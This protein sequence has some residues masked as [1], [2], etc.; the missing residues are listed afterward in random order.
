VR[1][2]RAR[3]RLRE[4][5][6]RVAPTR[7]R[8]PRL[9]HSSSNDPSPTYRAMRPDQPHARVEDCLVVLGPVEVTFVDR[10]AEAADFGPLAKS[11]LGIDVVGARGRWP[12]P[13]RARRARTPSRRRSRV[14]DRWPRPPL[15]RRRPA[16][17]AAR[18]PFSLASRRARCAWR[19]PGRGVGRRSRQGASLT[20]RD[21]TSEPVP[22]S[23]V[24]IT[25]D[26][27]IGHGQVHDGVT[28]EFEALIGRP[29]RA[30][31]RNSNESA[32][33]LAEDSSGESH[34]LPLT[35]QVARAARLTN[36]VRTPAI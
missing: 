5:R 19:S 28:E 31:R 9:R 11:G 12:R 25:R 4:L 29:R 30:R 14:L 36:L 34:A 33:T 16:V 8:R 23:S 24:G 18:S 1:A 26:D 2:T 17:R 32:P 21:R 22:S 20:T 15:R 3:S 13:R 27:E 7:A 35:H 6:H 10:R